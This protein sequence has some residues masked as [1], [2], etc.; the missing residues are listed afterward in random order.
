MEKITSII[1]LREYIYLLEIKQANEKQL[2][3]EQFKITYE[4]MQP[5]NLIKRTLSEL[6]TAPDFKGNILNAIA[7]IGMGYLSKKVVVGGTLNPL[8]QLLGAL[9]QVGITS[10]VAKN[11]EG[12]KATITN[13]LSK[14]SSKKNTPLF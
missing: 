12:I 10:I 1:E 9:L 8:K 4:N 11:G 14:F 13:L 5:V 7:G 2:L 3:K 6:T